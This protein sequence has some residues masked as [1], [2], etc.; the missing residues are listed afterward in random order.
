MLTDVNI[1][2]L[3]AE[4]ARLQTAQTLFAD[5]TA[6]KR[7]LEETR[8]DTALVVNALDC[9]MQTVAALIAWMPEGLTLSPEVSGC[10]ERLDSAMQAVMGKT[11]DRLR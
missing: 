5:L 11:D 3:E 9:A 2:A 7:E 4:I 8:A 1:G 10:K 6:A